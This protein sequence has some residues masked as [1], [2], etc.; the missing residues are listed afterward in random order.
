[1]EVS[2]ETSD[3][4]EKRFKAYKRTEAWAYFS[5]GYVSDIKLM[6]LNSEA[7]FI[8]AKVSY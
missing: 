2:S 3:I 1:M 8:L 4:Q 6:Q 7:C 5:A